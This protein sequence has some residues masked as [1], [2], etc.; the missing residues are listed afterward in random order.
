MEAELDSI[1]IDLKSDKLRV[2]GKAFAKFHQLLLTKLDDLQAIIE[3]HDILTWSS[4]FTS[5]HH[6]KEQYFNI[7]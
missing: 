1:V 4:L 7:S 3:N 6:G 5:A 2:R